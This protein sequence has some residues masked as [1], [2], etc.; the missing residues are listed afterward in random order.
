MVDACRCPLD[1]GGDALPAPRDCLRRNRGKPH[2]QLIQLRRQHQNLPPAETVQ[3][4]RAAQPPRRCD[5]SPARTGQGA[6]RFWPGVQGS[7]R[8]RQKAEDI[9]P[10]LEGWRRVGW[11]AFFFFPSG[12]PGFFPLPLGLSWSSLFPRSSSSPRE[13]LDGVLYIQGQPSRTR[14]S[15]GAGPARRAPPCRR[16]HGNNLP[17]SPSGAQQ[18]ILRDERCGA[19]RSVGRSPKPS[20]GCRPDTSKWN[21]IVAA[22]GEVDVAPGGGP[23]VSPGNCGLAAC[24]RANG[25]VPGTQPSSSGAPGAPDRTSQ[26]RR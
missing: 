26:V 14:G 3:S 23:L 24:A 22:I 1:Q 17:R 9:E 25:S 6:G 15:A 12:V 16:G 7:D 10:L 20:T 4:I 8:L 2:R 13:A 5:R 21:R 19:R 18:V 11:A